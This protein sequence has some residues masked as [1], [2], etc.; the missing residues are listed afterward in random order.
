MPALGTL[1]GIEIN[2][3]AAELARVTIWI[4]E[5][6]WMIKHGMA[7]NTRPIL[8]TMNQIENRDALL[9]SDGTEAAWPQADFIVGNPPFL[10]DK[11]MRGELGDR[12]VESLRKCYAGRVPGGADLVTY[13]FE[14]ARAEIED[15]RVRQAGL[16]STNSIRQGANRKLLERIRKTGRI[17]S[18][19]SDEPWINDGA[20]VR[21]SL[22]CFDA[23]RD[24]GTIVRLD[25]QPVAEIY[26]DLKCRQQGNAG[27]D[28]TTARPLSENAGRSFF[29]L[30]LAGAFAVSGDLARQWLQLSCNPNG[31]PNSDV[32]RPLYNGADVLQ[33]SKD[34]WVIDF[35]PTMTEQE[36][37]LYE[38]PFQYVSEKVKPNRLGNRE[39]VRA[40]KWWRHGRPRPEL[41]KALA[42]LERYI[43]TV[44]TAKHR[45]FVWFPVAVAPEHKLVVIPKDNDTTFG[46]LSSHIHVTWAFAT[47]G[48]LGVGNDPVYTSTRCFE[49]FPFPPDLKP[50]IPASAY[51]DNVNAQA[52]ARAAITLNQ[53]RENWLNPPEWVEWVITP[54]EEKAGY[55]KR[56]IA[57]LGHEAELKK[58]TLTNLYNQRPTW[59]DN[60]HKELDAAVSAAYGWPAD[61]S[62]DE[63]LK[64]LLQLNMERSEKGNR[65]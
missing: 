10:G 60:A 36:A 17:S 33:G 58:R 47:G 39:A 61:L 50:D 13:W 42:G 49:P 32:L 57:K 56:P 15:G 26:A 59:L 62:D 41:R 52:I 9:N 44:E 63:I 5:L 53:L 24:S 25:G 40:E 19:W 14:K 64:R 7:Y 46:I 22:V 35:G 8:Q 48:R 28:V 6:Q 34:R 55:P 29:G 20:A 31:R 16:V 21:V 27:V 18:V 3:Y 54:Q 51:D 30:C 2:E 23:G 37:A 4:G 38:A 12:Y 11:M 45:I 65:I 43:A 1:W